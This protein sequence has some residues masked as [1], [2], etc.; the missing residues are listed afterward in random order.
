MVDLFIKAWGLDIFELAPELSSK[1]LDYLNLQPSLY[2][3]SGVFKRIG[4]FFWHF[5]HSIIVY[6]KHHDKFIKT[7]KIVFFINGKNEEDSLN[8]IYSRMQNVYVTGNSETPNPFP[9]MWAYALSLIYFPLVI[10]KYIK[11]TGYIKKS[12][13]I[14]FDHYWTI[15]GY[16][17]YSRI[18]VK[19]VDP[20]AVV[21]SNH[22][23]LYHRVLEKAVRDENAKIKIVYIQHASIPEK[24]FPPLS[25]DYALLDGLDSLEKYTDAGLTKTRIFLIGTPKFDK[26]Y[27]DTNRNKTITA[28]GVCASDWDPI[29][30][31]ENL[32]VKIREKFPEITVILRPKMWDYG[33]KEWL[34]LADKFK[35]SY[36]SS[37]T[38]ISFDFLKKVDLIISSDS[39][40]LLEAAILNVLPI[41]FDYAQTALDYY[42]YVRKGFVTYFSDS[43]EVSLYM[44]KVIDNKPYIRDKTRHYCATVDTCHDG[45]AS[46]L[47]TE[48]IE[49]LLSDNQDIWKIWENIPGSKLDA[50]RHV[51]A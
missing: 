37:K 29:H 27:N 20:K 15:Y 2:R 16:Y 1:T 17:I 38:E 49:A 40:I 51:V 13:K 6:Y 32:L 30:R 25:S 31:V 5:F 9:F 11:S 39:T 50:Y 44:E 42:A 35:I 47:V 10:Y 26:Y 46:H 48:L 12:F 4:I 18:W 24:R 43:E 8:P 7:G 45:N 23:N 28:I 14:A 33:V 34:A 19:E 21:M 41:Y 22:T 36:S 3:R